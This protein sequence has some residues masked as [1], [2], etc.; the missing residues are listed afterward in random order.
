MCTKICANI[1]A[2]ELTLTTIRTQSCLWDKTSRAAFGASALAADVLC[3]VA[4]VGGGYTGCSAALHGAAGGAKVCLLEA[5][6]IGSG[7]SGRNAGL[8]NA[9]LWTPPGDVEQ[10]LGAEYGAK[11]NTLL[12]GAPALVFSLIDKYTMDAPTARTGTLHCAHSQKGLADL[13][14]RHQQ[15][16]ARGAPVELL[17]APETARRTGTSGHYGALLDHRAGTI[18]PLAY[19]R[20]L[21]HAAVGEGALIFENSPVLQ[22]RHKDG[23]WHLKTENAQVRAASL[24]IATNGYHAAHLDIGRPKFT[25][26][27]YCQAATAPLSDAAR[28][29]VL[30]GGHGCW[31]TAAVMSSFRLDHE[32]R[33]IVGTVGN[34]D[35]MGANVHH[36]W[37]ERKK[38]KMFPCLSG[39]PFAFAWSGRIALSHDHLPKVLSVGPNAVS[40]FGY[41]GRG[42]GPGTAFGKTAAEFALSGDEKAF[43]VPVI[44]SV[45]ENFT[46]LKGAGIELGAT[47]KHIFE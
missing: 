23:L 3:D 43:P 47:A 21:A 42:I 9:G 11:L 6:T 38:R 40:I 35:G 24:I 14:T 29:Q 41:S 17:D 31:D 20:A 10:I 37:L 2:E 22:A 36:A 45:S 12:A 25:P 1:D 5:K 15:L 26:L 16:A 39:V 27:Y 34:F 46:A 8:V 44:K 19:V 28:A 7:G 13:Q 32:G 33:L 30:P 18:Q 4:I